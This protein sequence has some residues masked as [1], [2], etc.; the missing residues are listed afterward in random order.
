MIKPIPSLKSLYGADSEGT[1]HRIVASRG[2]GTGPVTA[3]KGG[4]GKRYLFINAGLG[5][6]KE[7]KL[8]MVHRLVYEAFNGPIPEGMVVC[9]VNHDQYDNRPENLRCDTQAGNCQQSWDEGRNDHRV[10]TT[11]IV[12]GRKRHV[13]TAK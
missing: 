7:R 2:K 10:R 13:F 8:A 4:N 5:S 1:I 6:R 11:R 12:G 9:H 3:H